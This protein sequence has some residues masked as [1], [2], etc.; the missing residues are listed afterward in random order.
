VQLHCS[1][2]G[3]EVGEVEAEE[4]IRKEVEE[5]YQIP[6]VA[7][8]EPERLV[9]ERGHLDG[10]GCVAGKETHGL[11]QVV[12]VGDG[13]EE[14]I[15]ETAAMRNLGKLDMRMVEEGLVDEEIVASVD[16]E[17]AYMGFVASV[18]G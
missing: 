14:S 9:E 4:T 2:H 17:I 15:L 1:C 6:S 12:E 10:M 7:G 18:F 8:V 13:K 11:T 3:V 16:G 5:V